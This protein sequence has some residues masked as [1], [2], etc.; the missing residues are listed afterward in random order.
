MVEN[1]SGKGILGEANREQACGKQAS[2]YS[3]MFHVAFSCRLRLG[4][5]RIHIVSYLV[6]SSWVG[7]MAT[8]ARV[9]CK[10]L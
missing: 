7:I 4:L 3:N 6:I 9:L 8:V 5:Q 10:A 2:R 1:K